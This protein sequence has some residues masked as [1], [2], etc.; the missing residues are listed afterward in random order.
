MA[1]DAAAAYARGSVTREAG[2]KSG[3]GRAVAGD[4]ALE[5]ERQTY[6]PD[7]QKEPGFASSEVPTLEE[8]TIFEKRPKETASGDMPIVEA[9]EKGE[10]PLAPSGRQG[11]PGKTK[12]GQ[13]YGAP[14]DAMLNDI[15]PPHPRTPT[16]DDADDQEKAA[17]R[18]RALLRKH[19]GAKIGTKKWSLP[20]PAPIIDPH[21]FDDPICDGF[22]K[23]VWISTAVHNTE[24]YRQVFHAV[25]DDFGMHTNFVIDSANSVQ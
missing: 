15:E 9:L 11:T 24:I 17:F 18:A 1:V 8:K 7:G 16:K 4:G 3:H 2:M 5:E 20:T 10:V 6:G 22:W 21:G 14:A 25:P 12:D 13:P 23:D 19:L